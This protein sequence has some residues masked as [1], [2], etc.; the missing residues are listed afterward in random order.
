MIFVS[1]RVLTYHWDPFVRLRQ[2]LPLAAIVVLEDVAVAGLGVG[3]TVV[4]VEV[5]RIRW[6][7]FACRHCCDYVKVRSQTTLQ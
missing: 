2:P 1:D 6:E 7:R 3:D 4:I 5:L